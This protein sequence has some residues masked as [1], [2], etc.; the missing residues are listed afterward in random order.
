M[1]IDEKLEE[2][3]E[4]LRE[5]SKE[6]NFTQTVDLIVN[7]QNIDLNLPENRFTEQ[8]FLPNGRG[9]ERQI[10]IIA[11]ASLADAKKLDVN[12]ISKEELNELEGDKS[13]AKEIADAND[14]FLA[15]A[16]L[17][18]TI[19]KVLGPVLGPRG[20]MPKPF[21]PGTD[22]EELIGKSEN[23]ITIKLG[24]TPLI[25]LPVGAE[26]MET[27][28]LSENINSVL[29]TIERNLPKGSQQIDSIYVK[30]TMSK[31]EK[32]I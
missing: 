32:V 19:G 14:H 2:S 7:L 8:S 28:E 21:P 13:K 24:K 29:D 12:V 16:P 5:D 1:N 4:N 15:E 10:C 17:M 31:P 27:E 11:D 25:Q 20:K 26:S 6:R 30:L 18:P 22:L 23:S 9:K 3:I